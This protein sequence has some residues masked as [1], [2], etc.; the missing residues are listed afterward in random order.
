MRCPPRHAAGSRTF[1]PRGGSV[2]GTSM[3]SMEAQYAGMNRVAFNTRRTTSTPPLGCLPGRPIDPN[4]PPRCKAPTLVPWRK[5][6]AEARKVAEAK[7]AMLRAQREAATTARRTTPAVA[8]VDAEVARYGFS[9]AIT[10]G[11]R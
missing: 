2:Q 1:A 3:P 10:V 6:L 7:Q 9:K 11:R 4:D 8:K 5:A